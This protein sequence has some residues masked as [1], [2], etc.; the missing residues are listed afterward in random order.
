MRTDRWV[1]FAALA[2]F[3]APCGCKTADLS[4]GGARV[5][6]SQSAPVDSGWDPKSCR[7]IGYLVGRGGGS[8][9]GGFISNNDLIEYAMN[10]LRN[11]AAERGANFVQHDTPTLGVAGSSNGTSTTTATVSGTAYLCQRRLTDASASVAAAAPNRACTP[12]VTEQCFGPGACHGA[13]YCLDDGSKFS[14]CDCGG[15]PKPGGAPEGSNRT[16]EK[17]FP[18]G[19]N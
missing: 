5:A 19:P 2:A 12:G 10:D 14:A 7:A 1:R 8:F 13:Q 18:E 9:G 16:A 11:Q 15:T 4:N 6:T 3:A 17:T